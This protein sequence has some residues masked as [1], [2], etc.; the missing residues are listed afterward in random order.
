M[1]KKKKAYKNADKTEKEALERLQKCLQQGG[2]KNTNK[3]KF[4]NFT[5]SV[6][7]LDKIACTGDAWK[8]KVKGREATNLFPDTDDAE[9]IKEGLIGTFECDLAGKLLDENLC[10][11]SNKPAENAAVDAENDNPIRTVVIHGQP[12]MPNTPKEDKTIREVAPPTEGTNQNDNKNATESKKTINT[13]VNTEQS[14]E[15]TEEAIKEC[16][17]EINKMVDPVLDD[18]DDVHIQV[19]NFTNKKCYIMTSKEA[20]DKLSE[21]FRTDSSYYR[22]A[23]PNDAPDACDVLEKLKKFMNEHD[24]DN[25]YVCLKE[26]ITVSYK[27][28]P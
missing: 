7:H 13:D 6:L 26:T 8:D 2:A 27:R 28:N 25:D 4:D 10:S 23:T 17:D 3:L 20:A 14:S 5:P 15:P 16:I 21:K 19:A 1:I 11:T 9:T 22:N 24:W 18:S 12:I